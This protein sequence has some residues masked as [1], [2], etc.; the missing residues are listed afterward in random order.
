MIE[1]YLKF[2]KSEVGLKVKSRF[3][4]ADSPV[5]HLHSFF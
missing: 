3:G 5:G 4:K 1:I 2:P